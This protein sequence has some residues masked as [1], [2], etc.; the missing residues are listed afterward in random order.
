[1][2]HGTGMPST[3]VPATSGSGAAEAVGLGGAL[4]V[5]VGVAVGT[6]D[7]V[8]GEG[9]GVLGLLSC[10]DGPSVLHP[11]RATRDRPAPPL[12]STLLVARASM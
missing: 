11:A 1:M 6:A 5:C 12:S 7:V 3:T 8:A 10:P 2:P 4:A 9:D